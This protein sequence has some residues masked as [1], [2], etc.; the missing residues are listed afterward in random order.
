MKTVIF[1]F[2]GIEVNRKSYSNLED[3]QNAAN[4]YLRDCTLNKH[5][6]EYK[7]IEII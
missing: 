2:S 7:T 1:L 3:A 4:S 5:E 6:R